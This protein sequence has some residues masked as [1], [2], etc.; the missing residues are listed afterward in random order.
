[1]HRKKGQPKI[2]LQKIN[3]YQPSMVHLF[4][5]ASHI[6]TFNC[7][8]RLIL[9]QVAVQ[10][11]YNLK[12]VAGLHSLGMSPVMECGNRAITHSTSKFGMTSATSFCSH[13]NIAYSIVMSGLSIHLRPEGGGRAAAPQKRARWWT[14]LKAGCICCKNTTMSP[15]FTS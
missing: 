12:Q 2:W 11:I 6:F 13:L 15:L 10:S 5:M 1:M 7:T 8:T 14:S 9:L 4:Y 3:V